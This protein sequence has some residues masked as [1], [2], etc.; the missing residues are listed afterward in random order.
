MSYIYIKVWHD[1]R[2]ESRT[3]TNFGCQ[4][5]RFRIVLLQTVGAFE[6]IFQSHQNRF[7]WCILHLTVIWSHVIS[8]VFF[9]MYGYIMHGYIMLYCL[10]SQNGWD[11]YGTE[12][13]Q[14][15]R[16]IKWKWDS[17]PREAEIRTRLRI[18]C[19]RITTRRIVFFCRPWS[20]FWA[21]ALIFFPS[22]CV[23]ME[24]R[25]RKSGRVCVQ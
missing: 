13:R 12:M 17:A 4:L 18:L 25:T 21:Q 19:I 15:I 20:D 11:W 22:Q 6:F 3:Q 16:N 8:A 9:A 24:P 23:S 5:N 7:F 14:T 1:I 10:R 2:S